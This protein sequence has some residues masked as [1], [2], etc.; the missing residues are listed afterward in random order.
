MKVKCKKCEEV[1]ESK[2]RRDFKWCEC[3]SVAVDGGDECP[4][5][6]G[7]EENWVIVE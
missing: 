4:R 2:H 1:I 5:I 7:N 6:I 3:K